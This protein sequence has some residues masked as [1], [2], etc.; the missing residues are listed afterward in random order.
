MKTKRLVMNAML[1]AMCA[2][3]GYVAIDLTTIKL[4]F[5]SVPVLIAALLFGPVDGLAVGALG[6]FIYQMLRYGFSATTF[7]WILPHALFGLVV[8]IYAKKSGFKLGRMET[9]ILILLSELM[10][11][12]L[13]SGVIYADSKIYGYYF[14][15]IVLGSLLV[16]LISCVA[17]SIIFA[18]VVPM[19]VNILK[20]TFG[21]E[22]RDAKA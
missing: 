8:G 12:V 5:E 6:T 16:R 4:T 15:G 7:L 2:V 22:L 19:L 13:N 21:Q 17:K 14:E 3:L 10:I 1:I 20:K 9:A 11:T 18:L